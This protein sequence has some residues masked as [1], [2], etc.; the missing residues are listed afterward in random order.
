MKLGVAFRAEIPPEEL[1]AYARQAE[2][3]GYDEL[4]LI[5]DCFLAGGISTAA[6]ALAATT[7]LSVGL[8]IMPAV[9]RN[10]AAV[11]MELSTLARMFPGRIL[12][13]FG[14][15]VAEWMRQIGALP[16]SQLAA[17]GETVDVVR[18]LLRGETVTHHGNHVQLDDVRLQFPPAVVPPIATGVRG[19]KSMQ[20]S[21]RVADGTVL[22]EMSTPTYVRW[23][24]QQIELGREQGARTDPHRLTVY[25]LVGLGREGALAVRAQ[26]AAALHA[27]ANVIFEDPQRTAS[28]VARAADAP[29]GE[30]LARSLPDDDVA[31]L[32]LSHDA[33]GYVSAL[34]DAGADA[35]VLLPPKDAAAAH[36]QIALAA[37]QLLGV[38]R[39]T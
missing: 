23:A 5:E 9:M 38:A 24:R 37:Q 22:A 26:I 12:P 25:A 27:G 31:A 20:L 32:S 10:P 2:E 17:L 39:H 4:W 35:I 19:P 13:G 33:R 1:P 21:G 7:R 15:G 3:L 6:V 16:K 34:G 36:E 14:H 28:L 30:A 8:G 11:A 18:R 29:D